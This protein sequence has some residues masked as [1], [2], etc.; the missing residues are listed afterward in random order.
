MYVC[1]GWVTNVEKV[2][3]KYRVFGLVQT[4]ANYEICHRYRFNE[5]A[6]GISI[7]EYATGI[8][9]MNYATGIQQVGY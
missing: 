2:A 8:G 7:M 3:C 5:L 9:I 4:V 1:A 6:T